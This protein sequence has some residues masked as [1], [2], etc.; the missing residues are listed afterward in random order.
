MSPCHRTH[1]KH[2]HEAN[3]PWLLVGKRITV[4]L[5]ISENTLRYRGEFYLFY[6]EIRTVQSSW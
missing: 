3:E 5:F 6:D 4:L 1:G 2:L